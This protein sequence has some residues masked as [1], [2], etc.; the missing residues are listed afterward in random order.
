MRLP[1]EDIRPQVEA[2]LERVPVVISAPTGSG[3]STQVPRWCAQRGRVLVVEPRRVACRS[4]AQHVAKLE[5]ARLGGRV[6]YRVRGDDRSSRETEILFATPGVVLRMMGSSRPAPEARYGLKG[7]E[8][9]IIDEFHERQLDV[10]LLFALG[11]QAR[12]RMIVMSA[13]LDGERVAE[14]LEGVH[15][16]AEGR[17]FPVDKHYVAGQTLLPDVRGLEKRV[18]AALE[19]ARDVPGDVLVFLP[20]KAEIASVA[21][22]LSGHHVIPLHGGLSLD[23]QGRAFATAK[24][25][26]IILATNVAETSVTLPGVGV[27]IDSGLVRRTRYHNGRGFLTLGPIA[28]DSAGQRAGRAGRTSA[29]LCYRLWSREANLMPSTPPEIHREALA[30]LVLAA[31]ACEAEVDALPFLDPPKPHALEAAR[32]DLEALGALDGH[33]LSETGRRLFGL[34]IDAP[35]G[36]LLVEAQSSGCLEDAVDLVAVLTVQRPLFGRRIDEDLREEGCDVVASIRALRV[37][38]PKQHGLSRFVLS[39]ARRVSKRLRRAFGLP[40][41]SSEWAIDRRR[42]GITALRADWRCAHVAR[43]RKRAVMWSNGG[44]EISLGRDSAVAWTLEGPEGRNIDCVGVF[45]SRALGLG[46]RDTTIIATCV[47]PMPTAWLL[48]AELGRDRL[49]GAVIRGGVLR[50]KIERVFARKVLQGREEIPEGALARE[51]L[52]ERFL[53]GALWKETARQSR[54]NLE[55]RALHARVKEGPAVP[56][57]ETWLAA[58]IETLGVETGE[59]LALLSPEDLLAEPLPAWE[60]QALDRDFPRRLEFSDGTYVVH[61]ELQKRRVLLEQVSGK[62]KTPPPLSWLPAFRGFRIIARSGNVERELRGR[63]G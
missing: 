15:L 7:F 24:R 1:V 31:A 38:D 40:Q 4:L 39:E 26:K 52:A 51:A 22:T 60:Q 9:L 30:P 33:R 44:T 35:L 20:G 3:K 11:A 62:R 41:K 43:R 46:R 32:A 13:T 18:K 25:R 34:P 48:E 12:M 55:A 8:T 63:L 29:G 23:E 61:Y 50:A 14:H 10:D 57:F 47:M 5:K 59:D 19:Q 36:R 54:D 45:A 2:E 6:G 27:V 53:S 37:G 17:L 49:A 58:R 21:Q 16:Q 28:S 56:D 42:F